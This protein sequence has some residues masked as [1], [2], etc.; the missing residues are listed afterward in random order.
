MAIKLDMSKA[1]D[2][3]EW[4]FLGR[5]MLKMGFCPI[6]VRWI[7]NCLSTV[8]YSFNLNGEKVGYVQPKWGIRQGDPLSPY[9]F[10]FVAE[11]LSNLIN[12]AAA[13][14]MWTGIQ[15]GRKCPPI[16]H[17]FFAD[18]A[19][20]CC[21]AT[22][23][24][25]LKVQELLNKYARASGQ[26]INLDKS[27][28][29]YSRNTDLDTRQEVCSILGNL[30]EAFSGKYL[31]LPMV[32]GRTKN[33]VF[34][35]V[36]ASVTQRIQ[37]WK[38][39]LLS[40]AGKEVLLKSVIMALPNYTMSCFRI[41]KG[42]CRDISKQMARF[43][44]GADEHQ[45]KIHWTNWKALTEVKGKGGL[46]FRD[47]EM[48]NTALLAKQ[49][50]RIIVMPNRLVSRVMRAK[51]MKRES[52]WMKHAPTSASYLWK[53]LMNARFLLINGIRKKVGDGS[54]IKVW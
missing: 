17:L 3:V 31:G 2:R 8:S 11:A 32:I 22:N 21:K 29:Y 20:L 34:G 43:W 23:Q 52:D 16:T 9:L 50:W 49:L 10:L 7:M 24:E 54:T 26:L 47:L 12:K 4:Q 6:W 27:A 40:L 42:M 41:P 38:R 33:Q 19:L 14:K 46:G 30:R 51:Y 15:V 44:W 18:D 1:Y 25:A 48:F 13:S 28:I 53:S 45:R 36:K 35:E 39:N 5:I 37:S